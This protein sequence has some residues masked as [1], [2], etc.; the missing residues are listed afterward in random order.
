MEYNPKALL[1]I[2]SCTRP[3][4]PTTTWMPSCNVRMSSRTAVPPTQAW[5]FKFMKSIM[6]LTSY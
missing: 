2:I 4:V 5:I 3:G 1:W 6:M